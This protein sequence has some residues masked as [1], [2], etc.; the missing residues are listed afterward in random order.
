MKNTVVKKTNKNNEGK[1]FYKLVLV[2]NDSL[3]KKLVES[4]LDKKQIRKQMKKNAK[5]NKIKFEIIKIKSLKSK[6]FK[7]ELKKEAVKEQKRLAKIKKQELKEQKKLE[8]QK[9]KELRL[10]KKQELKEQKR[11]Q[12]EIAKKQ[13]QE[14]RL[15][16]KKEKMLQKLEGKHLWEVVICKDGAEES[17][18]NKLGTYIVLSNAKSNHIA[19]RMRMRLMKEDKFEEEKIKNFGIIAKEI[20]AN[21]WEDVIKLNDSN[22]I[23]L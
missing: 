17:L 5:E 7:K 9:A 15:Q 22:L 18:Y 19:D 14:L 11:I 1:K 23:S 21:N 13:K 16:K 3:V 12:K 6:K 8:K 4:N 10:Q 20:P 2:I